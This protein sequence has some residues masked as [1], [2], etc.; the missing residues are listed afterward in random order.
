MRCEPL[1]LVCAPPGLSPPFSSRKRPKARKMRSKAEP[2]KARAIE[3]AHMRCAPRLAMGPLICAPPGLGCIWLAQK[4]NGAHHARRSTK[5]RNAARQP[6]GARTCA[7]RLGCA[8]WLAHTLRPLICASPVILRAFSSR[9]KPKVRKDARR[10]KKRCA[11][12]AHMRG[13]PW[14]AHTLRPLPCAPPG[15]AFAQKAKDAQQS[16]AAQT[17]WLPAGYS[18]KMKSNSTTPGHSGHGTKVYNARACG[19]C[20]ESGSAFKRSGRIACKRE[21]GCIVVERAQPQTTKAGPGRKLAQRRQL[22]G[23]A[24]DLGISTPHCA[25]GLDSPGRR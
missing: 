18:F 17:S 4:V 25:G 23:G 1:G 22:K 3:R 16:K 20:A 11:R 9:K 10:S 8:V 13:A 14:L 12:R 24:S 7:A 19:Q 2:R 6:Q 15:L 5:P 21:V